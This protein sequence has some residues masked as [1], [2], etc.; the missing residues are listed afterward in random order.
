MSLL[1]QIRKLFEWSQRLAIAGDNQKMYFNGK[2]V[3][4]WAR[5]S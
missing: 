2:G 5:C 4:F 3:N 1:L